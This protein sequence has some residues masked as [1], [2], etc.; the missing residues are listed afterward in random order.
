MVTDPRHPANLDFV[1]EGGRVDPNGAAVGRPWDIAA[2]V[3]VAT[4]IV[5]QGRQ[6]KRATSA[7]DDLIARRRAAFEQRFLT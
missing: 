3:E 6:P 7:V 5:E 4:V 2:Y 1:A